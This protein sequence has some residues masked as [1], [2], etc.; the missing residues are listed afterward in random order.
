LP[1]IRAKGQIGKKI[2]HLQNFGCKLSTNFTHFTSFIKNL[3]G[4]KTRLAYSLENYILV[5]FNNNVKIRRSVE[6]KAISFRT[7]H[8]ILP[9]ID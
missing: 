7:D 8:K 6:T 4:S 2:L 3:F 1:L 5:L 9:Y